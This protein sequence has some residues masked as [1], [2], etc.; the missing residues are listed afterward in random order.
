MVTPVLPTYVRTDVAFVR[1]EGACLF[2]EDGERYLDFGGGIAV[3]ALGHAH[4]QLVEGADRAGGQALAHLQPLSRPRAGAAGEAAGRCDLRRHG[5]LHQ[6]R[7]RGDRVRRS[8][9]RG[10]INTRT[11]IPS[12]SASSPSKA[13]STAAR[14]RPSRPAGRRNISKASGPR[15]TASTRCAFGDLKLV[16]AGDR[17]GDR[18]DPD[19]ADPGRGRLAPRERG[20]PARAAQALRRARPAC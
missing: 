1:G 6:F 2:A 18:R 20:I 8:R 5:V 3:N 14:W 10:A 15:P 17:A 13:R 4:P 9:W 16:E 7:R 12:A 11:A 19:R